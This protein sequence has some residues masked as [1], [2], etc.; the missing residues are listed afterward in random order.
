MRVVKLGGSLLESGK[1][2]DCLKHIAA[3]NKQTV[4]VCG[5]GLFANTVRI[6]QKKWNFEDVTAH[7]MAIL[8]MQ[9]TALMCQNLQPEFELFSKTQ[10]FKNQRLSIWLPDLVELN[11]TEIEPS[12]NVTSDTLAAWLAN[13]LDVTELV[14]VKACDIDSTL[15]LSEL[16]SREI[17]DEDFVDFVLN[18]E[19]Y[20]K[21]LSATEFLNT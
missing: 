17:I 21:I 18:T 15:P 2:F 19:F 12:W 20:L 16:T 3:Q 13:E 9:Q 11:N 8:A 6:A 1:L 5:G 7:E 10:D 14:V 4:V